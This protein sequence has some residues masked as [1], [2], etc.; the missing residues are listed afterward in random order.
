MAAFPATGL[1]ELLDGNRLRIEC[2]FRPEFPAS[3]GADTFLGSF[4]VANDASGNVPAGPVVFI[5][6]PGEQGA[7]AIVL[8]Q[9][10]Y[11]HQRREAAEEEE[12]FFRQPVAGHSHPGVQRPKGLPMNLFHHSGYDDTRSVRPPGGRPSKNRGGVAI[13]VLSVYSTIRR[14]NGAKSIDFSPGPLS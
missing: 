1:H 13:S 7:A 10:I 9:E 8:N 14:G 11:V 4:F 6:P 2:H 3:G 12:E 5:L